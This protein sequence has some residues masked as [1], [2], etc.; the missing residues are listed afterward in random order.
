MKIEIINHAAIIIEC[1]PVKLLCDPWFV[2]TCFEQGW[3][4]KYD[5]PQC[6]EAART[7]THLWVS[8]FHGDHFHVATLLELVKVNPEIIVLGNHSFN[9]QLDNALK[10]IGFANVIPLLERERMEIAE[11]IAIT[12]YPTTGI[13]NMLLLEGGNI[14]LLNYNDCNLPD[15]AIK[16]LVKKIGRVDILLNNYNHAGKLLSYPL[17]STKEIKDELKTNYLRKTV[18]FSPGLVIPFASDHYYRA[19]ESQEQNDSLMEVIEI[20]VLDS[21]IIPLTVGEL[22]E[23]DD[24]LNFVRRIS[25]VPI[26]RNKREVIER[27]CFRSFAE[28]STAFDDYAVRMRK[29][30]LY[31]T[32]WLPELLVE[33]PDLGLLVA[34]SINRKIRIVERPHSHHISATSEA[35]YAWFSKPYGIDSFWVGAHFEINQTAIVPLRWQLL[36]GLLTENK[37][38]LLSMAKLLFSVGG[39]KFLWA[40]REEI[41]AIASNMTLKVGQR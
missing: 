23:V 32:F 40:R 1:G 19:A 30:F 13:D 38:D 6:F 16:L 9:F 28:L 10:K 25:S 11:N 18:L 29:S 36:V 15:K 3:G 24:Q 12:R 31:L 39:I 8:H 17:P 5:N 27:N 35:L 7:C 41:V 20:A 2:G 4:L 22:V 37:L 14:R 21:R 33:I 26:T 34:L